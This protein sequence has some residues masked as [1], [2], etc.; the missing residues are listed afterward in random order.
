[1]SL[2]TD[3]DLYLFNEGTHLRMYEKLGAHPARVGGA[4]GT[5]FAVWRRMR[6]PCR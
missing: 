4:D 5:Q 1:M 6:A 3:Q 2:L